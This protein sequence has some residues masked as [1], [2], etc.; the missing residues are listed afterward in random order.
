MTEPMKCAWCDEEIFNMS[1]GYNANYVHTRS[2]QAEC[3]KPDV[4][5]PTGI[6]SEDIKPVK[7]VTREEVE[8]FLDDLHERTLL[9]TSREWL[10]GD[11]KRRWL[12]E[13]VCMTVDGAMSYGCTRSNHHDGWHTASGSGADVF[14]RWYTDGPF[15][16]AK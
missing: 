2:R 4:A 3:G 7:G 15:T 1:L 8:E 11:G 9:P 14:G 6:K 16:D 5:T 12:N 13:P 10:E